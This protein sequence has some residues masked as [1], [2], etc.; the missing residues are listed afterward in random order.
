MNENNSKKPAYTSFVKDLSDIIYEMVYD[1]KSRTT[2]LVSFN[3]TS[4]QSCNEVVVGETTYK[5]YSPTYGLIS[6][7]VVLF[8]SEALEYGTTQELLEEIRSFIHKYLEISPFF[9]ELTPYYVLFSWVYDRFTEVPY[10]R[11][12][13]DYGSGKSRFLKVIGSTCY[14]PMFTSGAASVSPVFR[15]IEQFKGTLVLDE[16]DL[17]HSTTKSEMVKILNTGFQADSPVLRTGGDNRTGMQVGQFNVYG[18]KI[19]AT[20][21]TFQDQALESRFLVELMDAKLTR[22]DIPYNLSQDFQEAARKIRNKCLLWRLRNYNQV[23]L[24][25]APT[26]LPVEPRLIQII[27]PLLSIINDQT[28]HAKLC[29][30]IVEYQKELVTNRGMSFDADVLDALINLMH[31]R[32]EWVSMKDIAEYFNGNLVHGERN[33]NPRSVGRIVREKFG[34]RTVRQRN[35]YVIDGLSYLE[36]IER[37]KKRYGFAGELVNVVNEPRT[38]DTSFAKEVEKLSTPEVPLF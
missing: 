21:E 36:Q 32:A 13:G 15:I 5:P 12:L 2:A 23:G 7:G 30:F 34:I 9:E 8:P 3:G 14:K 27:T 6:S 18:P 29:N 31:M 35:G 19:V 16:A 26:G 38:P 25:E 4:V 10:L 20:R 1:P 11:A 24:I 22:T 17:Q 37:L 28:L 33:I